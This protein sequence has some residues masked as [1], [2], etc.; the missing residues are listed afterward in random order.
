MALGEGEV[1][2][3]RKGGINCA[4][5]LSRI[6]LRLPAYAYVIRVR[7]EYLNQAVSYHRSP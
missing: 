6:L 4:C 7:G 2:V 1:L 5:F 3:A